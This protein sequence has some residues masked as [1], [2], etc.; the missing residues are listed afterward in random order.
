MRLVNTERTYGAIAV[1]F[2]WSIAVLVIGL[3][4]LGI[5]MIRL[6]DAGF[7]TNKI[8]LVLVHK[9]IGIVALG[10]VILR[11]AWRQLN[12]LPQLANTVPEWQQV[13]ALLMHYWLYTLLLIQPI[14]G[15]LMSS[16]S[17]IPVD[18][19][20][21]GTLPDLVSHNEDLF[22][23][24]RRLH[25]WLGL[26]IGAL[27]VLHAAAALRHHFVLRDSTLRK[28]LGSAR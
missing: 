16:A 4:L 10:L 3:V 6:P 9:E 20:G 22:A 1:G 24:F 11:L 25:D 7:E 21:L 5:Y 8:T 19:M 17:G 15:W 2:H 26:L 12:P 14:V 13:A 18:F 28:M 23:Q 27:V